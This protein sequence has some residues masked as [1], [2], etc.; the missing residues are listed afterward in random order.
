MNNKSIRN[1]RNYN[2]NMVDVNNTSLADSRYIRTLEVLKDIPMLSLIEGDIIKFDSHT[3]EYI[4]VGSPAFGK[5]CLP[6]NPNNKEWFR[7][8]HIQEFECHQYVIYHHTYHNNTKNV[9][10]FVED[11]CPVSGSYTLRVA[12]GNKEY[13]LVNPEDMEAVDTYWFFNSKGQICLTYV[14]KD[15]DADKFR[16]ISNN[17]FVSKEAAQNYR[18]S[19]MLHTN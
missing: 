3:C 13:Y 15:K 17:C 19:I 5:D 12:M 18:N 10:C 14:G 16:E 8:V 9:F 7:D 6:L 11:F 4:K 2:M 1:R